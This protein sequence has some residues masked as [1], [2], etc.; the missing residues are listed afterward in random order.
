MRVSTAPR[1][2][3]LIYFVLQP[4]VRNVRLAEFF[5][6]NERAIT[7]L[8]GLTDNSAFGTIH[9]RLPFVPLPDRAGLRLGRNLTNAGKSMALLQSDADDA[10]A[11]HRVS[12]RVSNARNQGAD[13]IAVV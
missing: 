5:A 8:S 1:H 9:D 13:L 11:F 12:T 4:P 2:P 6:F 3:G 7:T 10:I